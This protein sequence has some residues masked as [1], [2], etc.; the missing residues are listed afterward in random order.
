[1]KRYPPIFL[2]AASEDDQNPL[3]KVTPGNSPPFKDIKFITSDSLIKVPPRIVTLAQRIKFRCPWWIRVNESRLCSKKV[4][5]LKVWSK[6]ITRSVSLRSNL[7]DGEVLTEFDEKDLIEDFG[8][9]N[10][11]HSWWLLAMCMSLTEGK[12]REGEEQRTCL[13]SQGT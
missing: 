8:M 5:G 1:M 12:A 10:K 11:C 9:H 2:L 7:I 6:A 4:C 3:Q 13:C